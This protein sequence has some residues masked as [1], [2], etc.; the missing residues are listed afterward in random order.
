M[1]CNSHNEHRVAFFEGVINT[2]SQVSSV[3]TFFGATAGTHHRVHLQFIVAVEGQTNPRGLSF[4]RAE[5]TFSLLSVALDLQ[6]RLQSAEHLSCKLNVVFD[7]AHLAFALSLS[8]P[9]E[10][11]SPTL[12]IAFRETVRLLR[13]LPFTFSLLSTSASVR[14]HLVPPAGD[15]SMS[16]RAPPQNFVAPPPFSLVGWD[17]GLCH[18]SMNSA[19]DPDEFSRLVHYGR[20]L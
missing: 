1:T 19:N 17:Q 10:D 11:L 4:R 5:T 13:D 14:E 16:A 9:N 12:F 20:P 7:E 2:A 3:L 18:S 15:R 6:R 8:A